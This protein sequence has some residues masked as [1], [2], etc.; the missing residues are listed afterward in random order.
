MHCFSLHISLCSLQVCVSIHEP[1]N[2]FRSVHQIL[3]SPSQCCKFLRGS[4]KIESSKVE[5]WGLCDR[6]RPLLMSIG[7]F[8]RDHIISFQSH[9]IIF[10]CVK[11][12]NEN[13]MCFSKLEKAARLFGRVSNLHGPQNDAGIDHSGQGLPM[14]NPLYKLVFFLSLSSPFLSQGWVKYMGMSICQSQPSKKTV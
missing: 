4:L 13:V 12:C 5:T 6:D 10:T 11:L 7:Q 2:H 9:A 14:G 8:Y 3:H 1:P